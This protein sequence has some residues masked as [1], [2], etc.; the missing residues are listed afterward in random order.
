MRREKTKP[1]VV[2]ADSDASGRMLRTKSATGW[3]T[4]LLRRPEWATEQTEQAW[5]AS[6]DWSAWT[7]TAWTIPT[8][9]TRRMH[10]KDR[11]AMHVSLGD[12]Y[13]GEIKGKKSLAPTSGVP[14][15]VCTMHPLPG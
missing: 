10:S 2:E 8:N 9:A 7:C 1:E 6:F 13:F 12:L 4:A 11:A 3:T 15:P 5:L 14:Q